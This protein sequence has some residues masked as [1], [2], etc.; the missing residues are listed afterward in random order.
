MMGSMSSR[1]VKPSIPSVGQLRRYCCHGCP[2]TNWRGQDMTLED[3]EEIKR[4]SFDGF[5]SSK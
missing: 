3:I 5:L 2:N 1:V 4:L